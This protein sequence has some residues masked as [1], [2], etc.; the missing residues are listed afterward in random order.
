MRC[1][2][3]GYI[4]FDGGE[5]CRNCGYD[6][7]TAATPPA[8]DL[9]IAS[10]DA[11]EGPLQDFALEAAR[12]LPPRAPDTGADLPL[13]ARGDR[14][15][16]PSAIPPRPPLAVRRPP[17]ALNRERRSLRDEPTLDL[18][19]PEPLRADADEGAADPHPADDGTA[20]LLPRI[21]A[22]LVDVLLVGSIQVAVVLLTL[23]LCGLTA[24]ELNVLPAVPMAA[25]L[26]M[27]AAG[28]NTAFTVAGGQTIGKMATRVRVVPGAAPEGVAARVPL[29]SAL[30]RAAGCLVSIVTVGLGY[31]P[32]LVSHDHRA[33]HDRLADTR[34]VRA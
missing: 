34:V 14:P 25:F 33:L 8:A 6:F 13:F 7:T 1:P 19:T 26:L 28:Y 24:E 3:C 22:A 10:P 5:R 30:I 11:P 4:S 17:P 29:G 2:K 27:L 20:R 9:P 16:V 32:A 15:R 18:G 31:L 21:G 12:P 23:R